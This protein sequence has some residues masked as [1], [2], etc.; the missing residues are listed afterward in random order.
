MY[1]RCTFVF[2]YLTKRKREEEQR[3]K[4]KPLNNGQQNMMRFVIELVA[5]NFIT[6]ESAPGLVF[7]SFFYQRDLR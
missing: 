3:R 2:I 1:S 6:F 5:P 7:I 4:Q